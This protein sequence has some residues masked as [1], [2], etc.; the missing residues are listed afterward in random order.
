MSKPERSHIRVTKDGDHPCPTPTLCNTLQRTAI[1]CN[2][3]QHTATRCNPLQHTATHC[4]AHGSVI[5]DMTVSYLSAAMPG[6]TRRSPSIII[7]PHTTTHYNAL[8]RRATHCNTHQN[9]IPERSHARWHKTEPIHTQPEPAQL[10]A[11]LH[12]EYMGL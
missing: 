3:L 1:H 12:R 10:W 5:H 4:S 9:I 7:P 11:H 2:P 8:Q 6:G